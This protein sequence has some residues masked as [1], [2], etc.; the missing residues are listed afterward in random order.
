MT[1]KI[2]GSEAD[3]DLVIEQPG[4]AEVHARLELK[5]NGHV[6]LLDAGSQFNTYLNRNGQWIRVHKIRLCV[7]D[8]IRLGEH[9]IALPQ[10]ISVFG[11]RVDIRLGDEHFSKRHQKAARSSQ[12]E[13]ATQASSLQRPRRNPL[14][15]KIEQNPIEQSQND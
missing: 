7:A 1:I 13:G 6:Y 10:L 2:I 4:V 8:Q 12:R 3:C 15:G 5:D 11:K 9:P 14:T